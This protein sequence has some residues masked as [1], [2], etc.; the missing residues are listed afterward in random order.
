MFFV[1]V[2]AG[3]ILVQSSGLLNF[4]IFNVN[5]ANQ[6]IV[7]DNFTTISTAVKNASPGETIL[8][9]KG[10][11]YENPVI[12]KS[13]TL[14][15]EEEEK[16]TVIGAGGVERGAKPVFTLAADD[17]TLKGFNIRSQNY[18]SQTNYATG[19]NLEGDNCAI[20]ENDIQG[21]YYGIFSS[22]QSSNI[23]S[24]NNIA[25][26]LK[27][28]I[29]ICGG[30]NNTIENNKI[31]GNA[32]SGIALGG[33]LDTVKGNLL[34]KNNRAIGLGA[35]Y[36]VVF[37][38]SISENSESGLYIGTSESLVVAN[39]ITTS[40]WGIHFTSFFAAPNNNTFYNNN[41]VNNTQQVGTTSVYNTQFWD[42]GLNGNYWSNNQNNGKSSQ[43]AVYGDDVDRHPLSQPYILPG[44]A[45]QPEIQFNHPQ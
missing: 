41:F 20:L 29:R 27:D 34:Q 32:Q 15:A 26:T 17:I 45:L 38:N 2:V 16:A 23:I 13:L 4:K 44:N 8:V 28:G 22:V 33:Y 36:T 10:T 39:N 40:K 19:I 1:I 14:M 7:P 31:T 42:N 21:T 9:R 35:S 11:Y 18:S 6:I 43:F 5:A 3:L 12:D 25:N 30:S 37:N 24:N